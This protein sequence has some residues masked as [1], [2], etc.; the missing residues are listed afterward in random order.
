MDW[1]QKSFVPHLTFAPT[2]HT[3]YAQT[4][5][6]IT[7]RQMRLLILY[8]T[9]AQTL[10]FGQDYFLFDQTKVGDTEKIERSFK[11]KKLGTRR[12]FVSEQFFPY[13]D[14]YVV[15]FP[16]AYQRT[17]DSLINNYSVEYFFTASDSMIR[18]IVY[19]W[20]ETRTTNQLEE[21]KK[22]MKIERQRLKEYNN[23]YDQLLENISKNLGTPTTNENLKETI[24]DNSA[25]K[26]R[27]TKWKNGTITVEQSLIF[28][29]SDNELG[30]FRIRVKIYWD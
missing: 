26:E 5:A 13:A 20:D 24:T 6:V 2:H 3:P 10:V 28:T 14:K 21:R 25:Y 18:L 15:G 8:L 7:L 4:L 1:S 19:D 22:I 12:I 29:T 11:S 17:G 27:T 9:L 23:K 16:I 30:T